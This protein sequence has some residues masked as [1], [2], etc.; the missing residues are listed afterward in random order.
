MKLTKSD[1]SLIS[2]SLKYSILK[3]SEYDKYPS[4]EFKKKKMDELALL[5]RKVDDL[6]NS[7]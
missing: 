7:N 5:K 2:E 4:Y 6:R 3:I 1:L